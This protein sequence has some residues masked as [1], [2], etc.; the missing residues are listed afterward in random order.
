MAVRRGAARFATVF[1][2]FAGLVAVGTTPASADGETR[3]GLR[4]PGSFTAGAPGQLVVSASKRGKD[5]V[6]VRTV[7]GVELSG[8]EANQV[9]VEAAVGGQW[10]PVG[11]SSGGAGT[12]ITTPVQ[13]EKPVLC[14]KKSVAIRYR[15]TFLSGVPSGTTT[16]L[17][18]VSDADGRVLGRKADTAR[19]V[20]RKSA[21]ATPSA[22]ASTSPTAAALADEQAVATTGPPALAAPPTKS[23]DGGGFGLGTM[24]ML[25]GVGMV[26]IGIA[27]LVLLLRRNRGDRDEPATVAH[28][29]GG[30]Y[31]QV[32]PAPYP[33][34]F[35]GTGPFPPRPAG[36]GD[37]TVVM[38]R[39]PH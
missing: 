24:V 31:P 29:P 35:P 7:L 27:L 28:Q 8:L 39:L 9:R 16:I 21:S 6:V 23:D 4:A 32:A 3:V 13:P 12:V 15:V 37:A 19:V 5:C 30:G 26:G 34:G 38:P 11:L 36:G 20:G 17:A 25:L 22:T 14:D 18:Q 10:Q 2:L 1:M 33:G